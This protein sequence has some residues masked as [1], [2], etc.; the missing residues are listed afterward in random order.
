MKTL[1]DW[2]SKY[3]IKKPPIISKFVKKT[4]VYT[5]KKQTKQNN[6]KLGLPPK[7]RLFNV[8]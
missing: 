2:E 3:E 5:N 7:V 6:M 1:R 8:T 4:T